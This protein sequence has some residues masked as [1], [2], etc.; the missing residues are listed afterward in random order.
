[1]TPLVELSA[2]GR[3]G[4]W[5]LLLAVWI[6]CAPASDTSAPVPSPDGL[7]ALPAEF[8]RGMNLEPIGGFGGPFDLDALPATL[9]ELR[10]V[11]VDHVALIPSFF[12]RRLGDST[13]VWRGGASA[14]DTTTRAAIRAVHGAGMRVL[15]KPHL[16]LEDRSDGAWRGD[17]LP[18]EEDWPGWRRAYREA[19]LGYARL[20][21]EERVAAISIGSELTELALARP[22]FWRELVAD[23][24]ELYPGRV[25]YAANWD[26]EVGAIEWWEATDAIGVDG[27]WPLLQSP[28]DPHSV[29]PL[30][31]RLRTEAAGLREISERVARPVW[32]TEIGYKSAEAAG[33]RPWEW[34]GRRDAVD[35]EAQRAIYEAIARE[36]GAA[37]R[38][39]WLGGLWVWV[40]NLDPDWSGA[41]NADFT[42]RGK[43]AAD[44]LAAWFNAP[45]ASGPRTPASE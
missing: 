33:Y 41:D 27:F 6:G 24:R 18:A 16:W 11:G 8:H 22:G 23:V 35:L 19:V 14:V 40:W 13:F 10:E 28:D 4:A 2:C 39:G 38:E 20:A 17:I 36:F 12:Q 9:A 42:P 5:L 44:L 32:L 37:A 26:R 3:R 34:H 15:L 7:P 30:R 29:E 21:A 45:A 25:T 31:A 43:P 1:M